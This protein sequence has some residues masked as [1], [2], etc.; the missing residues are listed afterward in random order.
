[1]EGLQAPKS[2]QLDRVSAYWQEQMLISYRKGEMLAMQQDESNVSIETYQWGHRS[3]KLGKMC[4]KLEQYLSRNIQQIHQLNRACM[5]D[6]RALNR[7]ELEAC[8][9]QREDQ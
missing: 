3:C 1:M 4:E 8:E 6:S 2:V 5:S 9:D 7:M